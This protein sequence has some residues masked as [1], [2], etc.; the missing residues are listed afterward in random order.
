MEHCPSLRLTMPTSKRL[1]AVP[2]PP[3][4]ELDGRFENGVSAE[5]GH[6]AR[7]MYNC[8]SRSFHL[9]NGLSHKAD[10][11]GGRNLT[12]AGAEDGNSAF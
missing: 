7:P 11:S 9:R 2:Y 10:G 4:G 5:A 1:S 8:A 3:S 6:W 12:G